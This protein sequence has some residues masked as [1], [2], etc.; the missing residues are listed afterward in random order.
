MERRITRLSSATINSPTV[1][2]DNPPAHPLNKVTT[3]ALT[4]Q[5]ATTMSESN[6]HPAEMIATPKEGMDKLLEQ[7][8]ALTTSMDL[9]QTKTSNLD[10]K[11]DKLRDGIASDLKETKDAF[12]G[13]I[14]KLEQRLSTEQ[15]SNYQ[16]LKK[17]WADQKNATS[18]DLDTI[19]NNMA[20]EEIKTRDIQ[21]K[22]SSQQ[23][24]I[25]ILEKAI[26][27]N[28]ELLKELKEEIE[29]QTERTNCRFNRAQEDVDSNTE[30]INDVEQHG[31][32]WSVRIVGLKAPEKFETSDESKELAL[33]FFIDD[34]KVNNI[35]LGD[36]DTA[37]RLGWIKNGK[38]AILVRFFR[39]NFAEQLIKIKKSL[40]GKGVALLEDATAR[41]NKLLNSL[42]NKTGVE[43]SWQFAGKVWMKMKISGKK[44]RVRITD[45]VDELIQ[46][47]LGIYQYNEGEETETET[48][49]PIDPATV[50]TQEKT[51]ET[52]VNTDEVPADDKDKADLVIHV[53]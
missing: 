45:D 10:G 48:E 32:R 17:L 2:H 33:K 46:Q 22:A 27:A 50:L 14:E 9:L 16:E 42:K 28:K 37:H 8:T 34:M 1:C 35:R 39:R 40:K 47:S 26:I 3:P 18:I 30:W 41:N 21:A 38:Q 53:A 15:K 4:H 43:S 5:K 19:R 36:L 12:D 7:M 49:E 44:V 23:D 31:R 51:S 13:K 11:F 52:T 24:Q 29:H 6:G 25:Y 20:T